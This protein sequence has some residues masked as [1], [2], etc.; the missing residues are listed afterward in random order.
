MKISDVCH[1]A[2][3]ALI[4]SLVPLI[5]NCLVDYLLM[6][7]LGFSITDTYKISSWTVAEPTHKTVAEFYSV[8]ILEPSNRS[9]WFT[10]I[11]M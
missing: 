9:T 10:S 1:V 6:D 11:A 4:S 3:V 5:T 2:L 7:A 8:V